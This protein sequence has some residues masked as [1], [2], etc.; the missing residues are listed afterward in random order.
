MSYSLI[1]NFSWS[2]CHLVE[3]FTVFQ[4]LHSFRTAVFEDASEFQPLK[5]P[6]HQCFLVL[7]LARNPWLHQLRVYLRVCFQELTAALLHVVSYL[8]SIFQ[9]WILIL[10]L[11]VFCLSVLMQLLLCPLPYTTWL[12]QGPGLLRS[13]CKSPSG[14]L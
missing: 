1:L 13:I 4:Q 7:F 6:W 10:T 9:V 11:L 12:L 2:R 5:L 8:H 14:N 3:V